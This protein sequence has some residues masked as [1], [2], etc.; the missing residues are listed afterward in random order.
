MMPGVR[1]PMRSGAA[2]MLQESMTAYHHG[3]I[4]VVDCR[5]LK[6]VTRQ[7]C[8]AVR[9]LSTSALTPRALARR[10]ARRS[11]RRAR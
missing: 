3:R 9:E 11:A 8:R 4:R 10:S 2:R 5:K 7:C 1:K 6:E